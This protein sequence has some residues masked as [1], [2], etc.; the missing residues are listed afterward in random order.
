MESGNNKQNTDNYAVDDTQLNPDAAEA[1]SDA[2]LSPSGGDGDS[3]EHS[4]ADEMEEE[5][6]R[7]EE[8]DV[9]KMLENYN[10]MPK[11]TGDVETLKKKV[12]ELIHGNQE[13]DNK[14]AILEIN[15]Q[16]LSTEFALLKEAVKQLQYEN[17][18]KRK[19]PEE[20]DHLTTKHPKLKRS[21]AV[22][23]TESVPTTFTLSTSATEI[24]NAPEHLGASK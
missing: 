24:E 17:H 13:K 2:E 12:D 5:P 1:G 19:G 11:L 6:A 21:Y 9:G 23:S 3:S 10:S 15:V 18:S 14:I 16:S 4:S 22:S 8:M 7:K 20:T